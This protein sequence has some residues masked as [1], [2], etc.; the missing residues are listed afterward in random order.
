MSV[1]S[2]LL[3]VLVQQWERSVS[4]EA[5]ESTVMEW[6]WLAEKEGEEGQVE[7]VEEVIGW[8]PGREREVR[9]LAGLLHAEQSPPLYVYGMSGTGKTE[10]VRATVAAVAGEDDGVGYADAAVT[11]DMRSLLE[12]LYAGIVSHVPGPDNRFAPS[13]APVRN[14]ASFVSALQ[15][16]VPPGG[17][18]Y[19][20]L[21]NVEV[22]AEL[23]HLLL[24]GLLRLGELSGLPVSVVLISEVV[25]DKLRYHTG[26]R[27]P[28]PF[29]FAPYSAETTVDVLARMVDHPPQEADL[30]ASFAKLIYDVF[31]VS[32]R[33]VPELAHIV[34]SLYHVYAAPVRNGDISADAS[35]ALFD[36][37][38][39]Y[40]QTFLDKIYLHEV[41]SKDITDY[42]AA[43][44]AASSASSTSSASTSTSSAL[45]T[46]SGS[47]AA[48]TAYRESGAD[49]IAE[50]PKFSRYLLV[51]MYLASYS[52]V[53]RDR[54]LFTSGVDKEKKRAYSD[55]IPQ[56]LIG[57]RAAPFE[58]I[59]AIFSAITDDAL[60]VPLTPQILSEIRTFVDLDLIRVGSGVSSS[61]SAHI[62]KFKANL[63]LDVV[64]DLAASLG[65]D[66]SK[67]LQIQ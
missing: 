53:S 24:P 3:V 13:P 44:A 15:A 60:G 9:K 61:S 49:L 28:I 48:Y 12:T 27:E 26:S 65:L 56:Q 47:S 14:L 31:S 22:V 17:R 43:A 8:Y 51:A 59:I 41:S 62:Q 67:Y 16:N 45:S 35:S 32:S 20:V 21:D 39:P 23:N 37:I 11:H 66:L 58:R 46:G 7:E 57:P 30:F 38:K 25:W 63:S 55:S 36:A 40:L 18:V 50:L 34:S 52:P 6:V 1:N 4:M 19:I 29:H 10:V 42:V 2:S 54:R 33:S 64:T 5:D